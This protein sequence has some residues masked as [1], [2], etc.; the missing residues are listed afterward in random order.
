[1]PVLLPDTGGLEL[2]TPQEVLRVEP[3]GPHAVRVRAAVTAIESGLPGALDATPPPA[4]GVEQTVLDDGSARL[5]N[6]RLAVELSAN[7]M[8]RFL[9]AA[10]GRELLAEQR[11]Q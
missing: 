8:L 10:T 9:H 1:M 5:V 3:W 6:G 11:P 7:G 4:P 2:R